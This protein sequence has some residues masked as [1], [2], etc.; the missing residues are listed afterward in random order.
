MGLKVSAGVVVP[1]C[2]AHRTGVKGDAVC[3]GA[4]TATREATSAD[5]ANAIGIKIVGVVVHT[6]TI[7]LKGVGGIKT[8]TQTKGRRDSDTT[9][10]ILHR[11]HKNSGVSSL[12]GVPLDRRFEFF[13]HKVVGLKEG[14]ML[15]NIGHVRGGVPL[16]P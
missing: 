14:E 16:G 5:I 4:H 3:P 12:V 7:E 11:V 13:L 6:A 8:H 15:H 9:H 2:W 1:G 10:Q